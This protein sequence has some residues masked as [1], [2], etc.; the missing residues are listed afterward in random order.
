MKMHLDLELQNSTS[1]EL[2][3]PWGIVFAP[4][5]QGRRNVWG[6]E[7]RSSPYLGRLASP[8]LIRGEDRL[9]PQYK[10][11]PSNNFDVPAALSAPLLHFFLGWSIKSL[12]DIQRPNNGKNNSLVMMTTKKI[13]STWAKNGY[14]LLFLQYAAPPRCERDNLQQ[15]Y[16]HSYSNLIDAGLY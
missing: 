2:M 4:L 8:I 1:T 14:V 12:S 11:G 16:L 13:N 15:C 7:D 3:A 6:R 9:Y 5:S 10:V